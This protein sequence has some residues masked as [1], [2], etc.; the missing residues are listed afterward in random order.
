MKDLLRNDQILEKEVRLVTESGS[1]VMSIT[2]ARWEANDAQLDLVRINDDEVPVCKLMNYDIALY[3]SKKNAKTKAKEQRKSAVKVKEIQVT[4]DI[5][6]NDLLTKARKAAKFI[7]KGNHVR[8]TLRL[9]GR[10]AHTSS[11]V[12][13]A[14]MR[15]AEFIGLIESD[16][17]ASEVTR[18][19]NTLT[20]TIK[21]V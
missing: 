11:M 12:A 10:Q 6:L 7:A 19:G 14:E 17:D 3:E 21:P 16:V 13:S 5:Q 4:A 2:R 8:V 20:T 18:S 9:G 15:I 1:E